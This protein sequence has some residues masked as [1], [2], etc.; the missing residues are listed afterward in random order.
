MFLNTCIVN[1]CVA[2]YD[3]LLHFFCGVALT[4]SCIE[5]EFGRFLVHFVWGFFFA[6]SVPSFIVAVVVRWQSRG[7]R[8]D[9]LQR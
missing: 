8:G 5:A 6:A 7:S 1:V 4:W 9:S 3:R 2:F